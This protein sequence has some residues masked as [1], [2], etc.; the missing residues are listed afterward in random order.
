MTSG[1]KLRNARKAAGLTQ[2]QL[3]QKV[4]CSIQNISQYEKGSAIK[5]DSMVKLSHALNVPVEAIWSDTEQERSF[6]TDYAAHLTEIE[7][8]F[9]MANTGLTE[10]KRRYGS[11]SVA[12]QAKVI[13]YINMLYM[14]KRAAEE[15]LS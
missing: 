12:D 5:Y 13:D 7:N 11:L 15:N 9:E 8:L 3:A 1:E 14:A 4:G 6:G 2:K 10:I